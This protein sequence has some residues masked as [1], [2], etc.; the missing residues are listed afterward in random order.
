[1]R[2]KQVESFVLKCSLSTFKWS[3]FFCFCFF[4]WVGKEKRLSYQFFMRGN[5]RTMSYGWVAQE[6]FKKC[7]IMAEGF[8]F[9]PL[10]SVRLR[11][12]SAQ[13]MGYLGATITQVFKR[14]VGADVLLSDVTIAQMGNGARE[15]GWRHAPETRG[16]FGGFW[17]GQLSWELDTKRE[18]STFGAR[19]GQTNLHASGAA[20]DGGRWKS[21]NRKNVYL[22]P[23]VEEPLNSKIKHFV[24]ELRSRKCFCVSGFLCSMYIC[25]E[26]YMYVSRSHIMAM[27]Q[28]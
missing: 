4:F 19:R 28:K 9:M 17:K 10:G 23:Y 12:F 15:C 13:C 6:M 25:Y 27:V 2:P 7:N 22:S 21:Q 14:A 11:T 8:R 16:G 3:V 26:H 5:L 1:M 18:G 24:L 20:G